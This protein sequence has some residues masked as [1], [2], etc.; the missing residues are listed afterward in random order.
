MSPDNMNTVGG[1]ISSL[2]SHVTHLS[3]CHWRYGTNSNKKRVKG[4]VL[5]VEKRQTK[6]GRSSTYINAEYAFGNRTKK[7]SLLFILS[8]RTEVAVP[9]SLAAPGYG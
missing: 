2:A 9:T 4:V 8:V 6:T 7:K 5:S 3:E 1:F